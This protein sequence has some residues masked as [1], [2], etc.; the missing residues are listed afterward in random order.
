MI[1]GKIRIVF[2][3]VL[4]VLLAGVCF[5]GTAQQAIGVSA[6]YEY[7]PYVNLL[8]PDPSIPKDVELQMSAWSFGAAFPL[9]FGEGSTTVLNNV[10]YRRLGFQYRNGKDW[11]DLEEPT[12]AHSIW[13]TAF[14]LRTLTE[15]WKLVISITTGI[16]SDLEGELS[17]E[18][19]GLSAVLGA[20][21]S[22]GEMK[23]FTLGL[24][25]AASPFPMPFLYVDWNIGSKLNINGIIPTNL[26]LIYK[27][28]PLLDLALIAAIGDNGFHGDPDRFG[29]NN[30]YMKYSFATV[31]SAV[32][33]NFTPWLHLRAEGGYTFSRSFSL[34]N[35]PK[36]KGSFD[37]EN[38]FYL[39]ANTVIGM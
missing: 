11:D 5:N 12:Q 10:N 28:I 2:P 1:R 4:V 27:P 7:I 15:R 35:G 14:L 30:P 6:G 16:S 37:M 31:G 33:F 32:Q 29:F 26:A 13:Y 3:F 34:W 20:M 24:G 22:F 25:L 19:F 18:D 17:T 23:N 39:R 36:E 8:D 9:S 38:T 21:R